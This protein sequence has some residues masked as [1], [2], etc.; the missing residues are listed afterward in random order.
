[1]FTTK[2]P[3]ASAA[4][5]P[6]NMVCICSL[7]TPQKQDRPKEMAAKK[8]TQ[9]ERELTQP[10]KW[11]P[12]RLEELRR[13]L[14]ESKQQAKWKVGPGALG[15][16]NVHSYLFYLVFLWTSS[17]RGYFLQGH[18]PPIP[19]TGTM[20]EWGHKTGQAGISSSLPSA[21]MAIPS[22]PI[23][24]KAPYVEVTPLASGGLR[25]GYCHQKENVTWEGHKLSLNFSVFSEM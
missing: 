12:S 19:S 14:K 3:W 9:L 4:A 18:P 21:P 11:D 10:W 24:H 13:S 25:E 22:P 23:W 8:N 7:M 1:M 15:K 17:D 20:A 5:R 2:Y 16:C 6:L